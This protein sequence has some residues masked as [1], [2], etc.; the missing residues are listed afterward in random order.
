M[1]EIARSLPGVR[2]RSAGDVPTRAV[3]D[4]SAG[5]IRQTAQMSTLSGNIAGGSVAKI[6]DIQG[7]SRAPMFTARAVLSTSSPW[8]SVHLV[9]R[10][11]T[12]IHRALRFAKRLTTRLMPHSKPWLVAPRAEAELPIDAGSP[13]RAAPAALPRLRASLPTD[14]RKYL[15]R[16]DTSLASEVRRPLVRRPRTDGQ[17]TSPPVRSTA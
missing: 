2:C 12:G 10:P 13:C 3:R 1:E 11:E 7:L 17:L 8:S 16:G 4:G 15:R 5:H 14:A 9:R 6:P